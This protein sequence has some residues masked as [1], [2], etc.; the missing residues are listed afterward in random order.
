VGG[1]VAA[2]SLPFVI[3]AIGNW[4]GNA[5]PRTALGS[6][7]F[8]AIDR[9]NFDDVVQHFAPSLSIRVKNTLQTTDQELAI[10]LTFRSIDDFSPARVIGQIDVLAALLEKRSASADR[11]IRQQIDASLSRQ[12]REIMHHPEFR[13]LEESWRGIHYLVRNTE[14]SAQLKIRILHL[15]KK[16]FLA[17]LERS[18][19]FDQ[20]YF[21]KW[22]CE[23]QLGVA[24]SEPLAA[25]I[26]DYEFANHPQDID[27]LER[28]AGVAAA[29]L[30]PFLTSA[31]PGLFGYESF[32]ELS[33]PR[34]LEKLFLADQYAK[35]NSLRNAD[36]SRFLVLTMPR[37]LSRLPY[38]SNYRSVEAFDF[39]EIDLDGP[40]GLPHADQ[41][42]WMN[43]AY[44]LGARLTNAFSST[45]W[46]T[47][48]CGA[49]GGG[50]VDDLPHFRNRNGEAA[51]MC[52]EVPIT[53]R[54]EAELN[55]LGFLPLCEYKNAGYAVFFGSQTV[56]RPTKYDVPLQ[57]AN[58]AIASR[59]PFVMATSRIAHYI[60]RIHRDKVGSFLER[61]DLEIQLNRWV[62]EY[63]SETLSAGTHAQQVIPLAEAKIE[64]QEVR[65]KPGSYEA[66]AW[67]RPWLTHE[68]LSAAI[69]VRIPL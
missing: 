35:W 41:L 26:G 52:T 1:A 12:L 50:K 49:Q 25:V 59:L 5:G 66:V 36:E 13:Q 65:G 45:G 11:L 61:N 6:R 27:L 39:E 8:V 2:K 67:L 63:V 60:Q 56:H 17:D 32:L 24:G 48:I 7:K 46:C 42:T 23:N 58:A 68:E 14:T 30:C 54:R 55:R 9:D 15:S 16:E 64:I 3:G 53:D 19:E 20:S 69:P 21:F 29:A 51:K 31:A 4:V 22:M 44:V 40:N 47:A 10:K 37:V 57:T 28:A 18:P 43:A 38:G 33:K 34:D 62:S